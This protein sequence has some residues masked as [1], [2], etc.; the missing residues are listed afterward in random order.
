VPSNVHRLVGSHSD[1]EVMDTRDKGAGP[2]ERCDPLLNANGKPVGEQVV[3]TT[4]F[5][6]TKLEDGSVG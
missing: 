2:M 5:T 1:A 4:G 6:Q 3:I